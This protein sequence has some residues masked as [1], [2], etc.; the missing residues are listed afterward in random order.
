MESYDEIILSIKEWN[1]KILSDN[2][3]K[4][5]SVGCQVENL[6]EKIQDFFW[7]VL[8]VSGIAEKKYDR[9]AYTLEVLLSD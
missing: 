6:C 7:E 5:H 8:L 1:A 2:H 9:W 4:L 3:N